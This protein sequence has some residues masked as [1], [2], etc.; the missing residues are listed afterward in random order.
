VVVVRSKA[1]TGLCIST[2]ALGTTAPDGSTTVPETE[3][4]LPPDC[5]FAVTASA[6]YRTIAK[7]AYSDFL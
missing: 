6:Q 7:V 2:A 5:A 4:E 3:L 1:L